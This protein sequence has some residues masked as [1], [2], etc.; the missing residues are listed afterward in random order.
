MEETDTVRTLFNK[1]DGTHPL[2]PRLRHVHSSV[3]PESCTRNG[4][5][6][7][8]NNTTTTTAASRYSVPFLDSLATQFI[9]AGTQC[10]GSF[11][12]P[13]TNVNLNRIGD[14]GT[15]AAAVT[16]EQSFS[17]SSAD[18]ER[19]GCRR[20]AEMIRFRGGKI[21]L[22]HI[23]ILPSDAPV[24]GITG[25]TVPDPAQCRIEGWTN[26]FLPA[27]LAPL[28][29]EEQRVEACLAAGEYSRLRKRI[30]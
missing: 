8:Q 7:Q 19:S 12:L 24:G 23:L 3:V 21:L 29:T 15:T 20:R 6:H 13:G 26:N 11:K 4:Y 5:H 2:L 18:D 22:N 10:I 1:G 14:S 16:A 17:Q 27:Y 25:R 9:A 30:N 28:N